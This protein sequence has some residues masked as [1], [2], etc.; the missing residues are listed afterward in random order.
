MAPCYDT[1]VLSE[2]RQGVEAY[3]IAAC[4]AMLSEEYTSRTGP[5]QKIQRV[6][7]FGNWLIGHA[8]TSWRFLPLRD[9][10][11]RARREIERQNIEG[12]NAEPDWSD[13]LTRTYHKHRDVS[14]LATFLQQYGFD[15]V[16]AFLDSGLK[17]FGKTEFARI[18]QHIESHDLGIEIII[19]GFDE[20]NRIQIL[21]IQHP[22]EPLDYALQG[23]V[24]IGWGALLA[25]GWLNMNYE[26]RAPLKECM[27]R[28]LQAKF[29][30]ESSPYVGKETV[31]MA[32]KSN[33]EVTVMSRENID[34]VRQSW[35]ESMKVPG[36]LDD[37]M[38]LSVVSGF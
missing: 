20:Y 1:S 8:G 5:I 30:A 31:L 18:C 9:S 10:L 23:H 17:K 3:V 32:M 21:G 36:D 2:T 13:L 27:L 7:F 24:A 33:G 22:G 28:V 35:M 26:P 19:G 6:G 37:A 29:L 14:I 15:S 25:T 38:T 16:S 34:A 11:T 4:D 12:Q